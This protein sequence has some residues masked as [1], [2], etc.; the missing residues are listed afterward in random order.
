MY[1]KVNNT[2][3]RIPGHTQVKTEKKEKVIAARR[4]FTPKPP[5]GITE[6]LHWF[7]R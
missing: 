5:S 7:V 6:W 2:T 1:L 4:L 3:R